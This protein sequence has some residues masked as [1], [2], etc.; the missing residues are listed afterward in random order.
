MH[1]SICMA[2]QMDGCV[3]EWRGTFLEE[4][5]VRIVRIQRAGRCI[6]YTPCTY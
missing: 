2:G 1:H 6:F 3:N 4:I 5:Y